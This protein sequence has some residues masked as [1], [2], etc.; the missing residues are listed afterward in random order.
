MGEF[1]QRGLPDQLVSGC[2]DV[3]HDVFLPK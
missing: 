2:I 3:R 1:K